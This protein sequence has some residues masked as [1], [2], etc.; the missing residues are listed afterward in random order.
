M[1]LLIA[2][3]DA[4]FRRL[5]QRLLASEY[6]LVIAQDG[7]EAWEVLQKE[8]APRMAVLDWVMPGLSGPQVCR[9]VRERRDG[10]SYYLVLLTVRNGPGDIVAGLE[11]GADDY[12][13]KPFECA[14]VRARLK[15]GARLM[16]VQRALREQADEMQIILKRVQ[17]LEEMLPVCQRC[18]LRCWDDLRAEDYKH[19]RVDS[20][21]RYCPACEAEGASD[22]PVKQPG[23]ASGVR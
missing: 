23:I 5:L 16:E 9:K 2:E 10:G 15:T 18:G 20:A 12:I 19:G 11:A 1:K 22:T 8:D 7:A 17:L 3:D 6:E 14:E 13:T 21:H 4:L